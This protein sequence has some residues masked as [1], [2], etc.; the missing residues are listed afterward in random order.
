ML[1]VKHSAPRQFFLAFTFFASYYAPVLLWLYTLTTVLAGDVTPFVA[2]LIMT[3][4]LALILIVLCT[5][6]SLCLLPLKWLSRP[7][8]TGLLMFAS[9]FILGEFIPEYL[10]ELSFS[11]IRLGN[12]AVPF[13]PF[14]QTASLFGSLFISLLILIISGLIT[15]ALYKLPRTRHSGRTAGRSKFALRRIGR[16]ARNRENNPSAAGTG[17]LFRFQKMAG[18]YQFNLRA[19]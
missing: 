17:Q 15:L 3:L 9:L 18:G 14:I 12:A 19:L 1:C 16:T 5:I 8:P 2:Y 4:A 7:S 13:T 10:G 11:W 6:S